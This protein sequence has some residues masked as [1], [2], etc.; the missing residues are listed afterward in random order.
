M[1]PVWNNRERS[2][3]MD[4]AELLSGSA[5]GA[6]NGQLAKGLVRAQRLDIL[7]RD[8]S[9]KSAGVVTAALPATRWRS[10]VQG[11]DGAVWGSSDDGRIQR[12]APR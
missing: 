4:T 7:A 6:W 12:V 1:R 10:L 8:A 9:G 3:G 2:E 5:W 11:P